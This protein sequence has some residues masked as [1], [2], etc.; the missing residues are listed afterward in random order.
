M[1]SMST[2]EGNVLV[3]RILD[4]GVK[5]KQEEQVEWVWGWV[6]I[7]L[8]KLSHA[9]GFEEATDRAVRDAAFNKLIYP[10]HSTIPDI[11]Q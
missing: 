7:Q 6:L 4:T 1:F 5:L 2:K 11:G 9:E 3:G 8:G 10:P